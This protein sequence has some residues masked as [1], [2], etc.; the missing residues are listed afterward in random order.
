MHRLIAL[1]SIGLLAAGCAVR[2][3]GASSATGAATAAR[4]TARVGSA[5]PSPA[6]ATPTITPSAT[7][8][9]DPNLL[10][11]DLETL[12]PFDLVIARQSDRKLLRFS[13]SLLNSGAGA[14]EVEGVFNEASGKTAATQH[15]YKVDGSLEEH[16]A[17]EFIFHPGHNHWHLENFALFEVWSLAPDGELDAVVAFTDKLSYCLRDDARSDLPDAAP[18]AVYRQCNRQVQGISVGWTDT[19]A[20]DTQGQ[21]V[22]ITALADGTYALRSTVDPAN[23]LRESDDENN[24]AVVFIELTGNRVEIIPDK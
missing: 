7:P 1:A 21:I 6:P 11:P 5:T 16:A 19:Y 22:D 20:F 18:R 10:L 12:P 24:S 17:G 4:S 3:P 15:I 23:Q 8:R 9:P 14:L 2:G 13:N